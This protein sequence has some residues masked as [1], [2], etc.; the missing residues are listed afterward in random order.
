M[1]TRQGNL[2]I[3][4]VKVTENGKTYDAYAID[5]YDLSGKRVRFR[6]QD[7]QAAR[8][9]LAELQTRIHN[10]NVDNPVHFVQTRLSDDQVREAE[11]AIGLIEKTERGLLDFVRRALNGGNFAVLPKIT[12]ETALDA[13]L[14]EQKDLVSPRQLETWACVLRQYA[15]FAGDCNLA[16]IRTEDIVRFIESLRSRDGLHRAAPKTRKN[17]QWDLHRLFSWCIDKGW[18]ETNP[19]AKVPAPKVSRG[20]VEILP[21]D[22]CQRLMAHVAGIDGGKFARYFALALFAG[23][24]PEELARLSKYPE[25]I[26]LETGTVR[27]SEEVSKTNRE[28][29]V[30]IQPN[31]AAWLRR[32]PDGP[33]RVKSLHGVAVIRGAFKLGHDVLRHTFISN[34]VTAFGKFAET[35]VES[36]NTETIIRDHYYARVSDPDAQAFWKIL[37]PA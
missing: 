33:L 20:F 6:S 13:F 32:F 35:A 16:D 18:L 36:G 2:N 27:I 3:K 17:A 37:P 26:N 12:L 11:L 21:L 9:K 24:R 25:Q 22:T 23:I 19:A 10:A 31:L 8:L 7:Q 14:K 29:T 1:R 28:R 15:D 4:K 34:H 30:T 5:G